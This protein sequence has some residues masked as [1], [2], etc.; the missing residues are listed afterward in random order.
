MHILISEEMAMRVFKTMLL[1]V[2]CLV[3]ISP[4]AHL[5]SVLPESLREFFS[6]LNRGGKNP[7]LSALDLDSER[8]ISTWFSSSALLFCSILLT[9]IAYYGKRGSRYAGHW[10]LLALIFLLMSLDEAA[11]FH[12]MMIPLR[13][14]LDLGGFL[15]YAWVIPGAAF[16]LVFALAYLKFFLEL[17]SKSRRLFAIAGILYIWGVLGMEM[18]SGYQTDLYGRTTPIHVAITTIEETF[19]MLGLSIFTYALMSY[20]ASFKGGV[21]SPPGGYRPP[22]GEHHADA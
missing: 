3:L 6:V 9:T 21:P 7:T 20:A 11:S 1:I 14:A 17:P 12:E 19:E 18:I 2:L 13:S 15:F 5:A 16:V 4:V 22:R 10:K 8:S